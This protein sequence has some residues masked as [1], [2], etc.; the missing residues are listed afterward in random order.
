MIAKKHNAEINKTIF[1]NLSPRKRNL[2]RSLNNNA[3]RENADIHKLMDRD[4]CK[5]MPYLKDQSEFIRSE[6]PLLSQG[7]SCLSGCPAAG[8]HQ[9]GQVPS[10]KGQ[11]RTTI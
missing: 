1:F 7:L 4:G 5:G 6:E 8:G 3:R 10:Y 9:C 11:D 2:V